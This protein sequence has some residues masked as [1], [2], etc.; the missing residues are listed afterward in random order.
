MYLGFEFGNIEYTFRHQVNSIQEKKKNQT[1][2]GAVL[3]CC[4]TKIV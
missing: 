3:C 4:Q 2:K 1:E